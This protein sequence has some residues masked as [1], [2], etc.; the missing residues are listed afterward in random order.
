MKRKALLISLS[1]ALVALMALGF[2]LAYF[3]DTEDVSNT[4]TVGNVEITLDEAKVKKDTSENMVN[5]VADG[6]DRV[7]SNSYEGLV[8]G[9]RVLKDPSITNVGSNAAYIRVTIKFNNQD[10]I[11][12]AL[13][14]TPAGMADVVNNLISTGF[15]YQCAWKLGS[16]GTYGSDSGTADYSGV[17]NKNEKIFVLYFTNPLAAG[18]SITLFDGLKVPTSF[19]NDD[20]EMFKNLDISITADA[21]QAEGFNSVSD[22]FAAF[23]SQMNSTNP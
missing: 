20:M 4:F 15:S 10:E 21:I 11:Y 8:P 22:A 2:T 3:T 13:G 14:N 17:L 6:T 23:D 19:D 5:Y 9:S 7:A 1:V 18:T 12:N 16:D